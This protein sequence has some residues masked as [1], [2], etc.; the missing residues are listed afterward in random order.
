MRI[1][2]D[3]HVWLWMVSAPERLPGAIAAALA[4]ARNELWFSAVS[5]WEIAIKHDLGRL[6]LPDHPR[7]FIAP[8]LIR[9]SVRPLAI[10]VRHVVEV[11]GLPNHHR[12]PF[13]R[14]LIAQARS[15]Q[16]QL[17]TVDRVFAMYDVPLL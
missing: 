12:D 10:E 16:M 8:R 14:L 4:D 17:A 15:E 11:S 13:D 9:D 5:G 3:T 7:A 2:L 6:P 1:L